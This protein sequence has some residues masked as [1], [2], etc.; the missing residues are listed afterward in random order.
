MSTVE[1]RLVCPACAARHPLRRIA[2]MVTAARD[3]E[4]PVLP[5]IIDCPNC[6]RAIEVP[7]ADAG[8]SVICASCNCFL[9]CL[10]KKEGRPR[11]LR[12]LLKGI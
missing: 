7:D 1:G 5:R 9:G 11:W 3:A 6:G 4:G 12:S 2:D 10:K 8:K